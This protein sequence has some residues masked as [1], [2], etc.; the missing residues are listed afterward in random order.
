[1]KSVAIGMALTFTGG[2]TWNGA[3]E[4]RDNLTKGGEHRL[5]YAAGIG[6]GLGTQNGKLLVGPSV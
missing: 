1:M 4:K 6:A 2:K 5:L 3:D